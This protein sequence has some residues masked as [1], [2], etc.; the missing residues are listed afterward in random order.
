MQT[1]PISRVTNEQKKK[2]LTIVCQNLTQLF[3][4]LGIHGFATFLPPADHFCQQQHGA[5]SKTVS[6]FLTPHFVLS[7]A[8][9]AHPHIQFDKKIQENTVFVLKCK[10][11]YI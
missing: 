1:E 9:S 4:V 6:Y 8:L 11:R 3:L 7:F 5:N 10:H 2:A